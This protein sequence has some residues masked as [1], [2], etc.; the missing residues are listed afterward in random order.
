MKKIRLFNTELFLAIPELNIAVF[1]FLLNFVWEFLQ[2][3]LFEGMPQLSHWEGIKMCAGAA[4]ADVAIML[5]GYWSI[6]ATTRSRRWFLAPGYSLS[7]DSL[8]SE[9]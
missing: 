3:P 1:A 2:V 9:S 8:V 6:A 4:V 7:E 5:V